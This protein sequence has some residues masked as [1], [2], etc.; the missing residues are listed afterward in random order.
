MNAC[1][2][3]L[4]LAGAISAAT[5]G[6]ALDYPAVLRGSY[7]YNGGEC[8]NPGLVL[9]QSLRFNDVDVGCSLKSLTVLSATRFSTVEQCNREGRTWSQAAVFS[10]ERST[11]R[12]TEDKVETLFSRCGAAAAELPQAATAAAAAYKITNCKVL[13]GQAGVTT[14]LNAA[15]SRSGNVVRDFDDYTFRSIGKVKINKIDILIGQL[16]RSDGTV[17]EAQSWAMAE[18]WECE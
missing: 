16:I 1:K 17:S 3:I 15:L 5:P 8:K 18:E 14:F 12:L 7:T 9:Q 11:L 4:T 10:L 2:A 13:P 6:L